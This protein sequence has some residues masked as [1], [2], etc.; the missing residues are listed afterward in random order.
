MA[1][2]MP[3][4]RERYARFVV[5]LGFAAPPAFLLRQS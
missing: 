2:K 4:F 5:A 3:L 1:E